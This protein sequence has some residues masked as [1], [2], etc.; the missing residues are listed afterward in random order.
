[1]DVGNPAEVLKELAQVERDIRRL[2][3]MSLDPINRQMARRLERMVR[4][5]RTILQTK[6]RA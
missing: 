3:Q 1:M 6:E 2:K 4:L 5:L